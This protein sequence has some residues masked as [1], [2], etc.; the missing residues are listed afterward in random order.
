MPHTLQS[1]LLWR[2]RLPLLIGAIVL[3][4]VG[5]FM[6]QRV[7]QKSSA[8]AWESVIHSASVEARTHELAFML[9]SVESGALTRAA[10]TD[11]PGLAERI[12]GARTSIDDMMDQ[13]Q[14]MTR[15]NPDLQ[16]RI[17]ELRTVMGL[18]LQQI[19]KILA[20]GPHTRPEDIEVLVERY[21]VQELFT[22]IIAA[23][24]S[25]LAERMAL[26]ERANARYLAGGVATVLVQLLLLG[27][28]TY[29][30][31][32]QMLRRVH[33]ERKASRAST[34]ASAVLDT[35]REPIVLV[36]A[37]LAVVM[38]NAAFAELYGV[39]D[40][41]TG[42][43]LAGIGEG[44]WQDREVLQRLT[45]VLAR[46]REL[47]DHEQRQLTAD[48]VE[49]TML[50]NA[51]SMPLPDLDDAVALISASDISARKASERQ[52]HEL[53]KQ[54]QGKIEQVSDVNRELEAFSYSVSHDLRAPL[55]HISGFANKLE[56]HLGESA[57]EKSRH[58]LGVIA[59]SAR[60][61]STLIDDLLVYSRLGRSAIRLQNIDLQSMVH[62]TRAL[63][64]ANAAQDQ[65]EHRI[66][67][68]IASLPVVVGDENM[69]H[70]VWLNLLGNAIKYSMHSEPARIEVGYTLDQDGTHRFHV[71]DNGAGFDMNY[72]SKLF[73]VFQRMHSASQFPGTGIG[74][75]SVRRVLGRHGGQ[76]WAEAEPGKGATFHFTLPP[77]GD[78]HGTTVT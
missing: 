34:R 12:N 71:S 7:A 2:W 32:R 15:D 11:G 67:W 8:D 25:R 62:E 74:L 65:P 31:S 35:V 38:Y 75:A 19:D 56:R 78:Q 41:I 9:R 16:V 5:P 23:E 55:R 52:I 13:L 26:A 69:L 48:G 21:K 57:D 77:S 29:F 47:W 42:Q 72:A 6:L 33:A 76:I 40:S 54:L 70:Q 36:D 4:V 46:N 51:R 14:E 44:A 28:L 73:G 10:G 17:G 66:E 20:S 64:E 30:S 45:D 18:R 49:R 58:Y 39:S 60:R 68:E 24:Q 27:A 22:G 37:G 3:I 50:I 61:M 63:L 59:D 53:N 43:N 1:N